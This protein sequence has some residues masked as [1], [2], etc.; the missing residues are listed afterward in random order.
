MNNKAEVLQLICDKFNVSHEQMKSTSRRRDTVNARQMYA[1]WLRTFPKMTLTDIA[2][3]IRDVP[4]D[5]TTVI[6]SI[7]QIKNLIDTEVH[8]KAI[9]DSLPAYNVQSFTS[10]RYSPQHSHNSPQC[11]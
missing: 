10:L 11:Q 2:K 6:H 3:E 7:Y 5:H 9:W 4:F 8:L 1:Y